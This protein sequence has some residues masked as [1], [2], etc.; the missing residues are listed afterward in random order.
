MSEYKPK[1]CPFCGG[2]CLTSNAV[3]GMWRVYCEMEAIAA[4]GDVG[5]TTRERVALMLKQA[6]EMRERA[7]E[8][9]TRHSLYYG[10][11]DY[12]IETV[13]GDEVDYILHGDGGKEEK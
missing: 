8:V 2:E 7:E 10:K 5:S 12:E 11:V 6:A 3:G 4:S 9:R 13:V 1:P